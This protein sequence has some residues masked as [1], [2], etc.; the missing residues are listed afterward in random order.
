[1]KPLPLLLSLTTAAALGSAVAQTEVPASFALPSDAADPNAPGFQV[2]VVQADQ[3][4]VGFVALETTSARA[5]AQLAGLLTDPAT[6]QPYR[7][8]ADTTSFKP[9]GTYDEPFVIDYEQA[10]GATSGIPGIPGTTQSTD[11]IALEAVTYLDLAA[12]TYS[13]VVNSDDGFR[14]AVGS[15]ARDW[16]KR[17]T[18]G[19]FEG[20]R[21]AADTVFN[22]R[23]TQAGLYS[24][25]LLWYEGGGGANV[26]W[27]S[28]EPGNPANRVLINDSSNPAGIKAYR[29]ITAPRPAFVRYVAPAPNESGVSPT[30]LIQVLLGDGDAAQ[31][32]RNSIELYLN[33]AKVSATV[34]QDGRQTRVEFDPP[35]LLPANSNHKVRLVFKDT[36]ATPN[37]RSEE[38]TF[39]VR[40]YVSIT[41]P[42]PLYFENF[43]GTAEGSLPVGWT[44]QTFTDQSGSSSD[45]DLEN[46]DSA[47]YATW[48][49]VEAS[50]FR[51]PFVTYSNPDNPDAWENDYKRVLSFNPANVVNGEVVR[52]LAK[53]RFVFGNSGYR[54]G[55]SQVMYLFSPDFDLRGKTDVFVAFHSLWEQNQDSF[56][57]LEYSVDGGGSWLPILYMLDGPDVIRD[58][59]GQIDAV[60]TLTTE[61]GDVARYDDPVTGETKGGFY[62]AFIAAPITQDLAPFISARVNDNPIESK[63]VELFRLPRADNQ[64]QVRFRFA[65][66]GTD[67]WYWGI[68]NF[69][70]YSIPVVNPPEIVRQPQDVAAVEGNPATFTVTASGTPPLTYQWYRG[71]QSIAGAT[72]ASYTIDEVTLSDNGALFYARV[73]NA[74]GTRDSAKAR[75]T[76]TPRPPAVFG[77]WNFD[78]GDLSRAAGVG[79][80]DYAD[81]EATRSLT[82]FETTDGVTVPHIGGQPAKFMRVPVFEDR[83]NGY[84]LTMPMPP[85]G[86]G[87]YV[88]QYTIIWDVLLPTDINWMPFFNTDPGNG[89][90]A[91]FYVSNNGALGIGALGYSANGL[92]QPNTWY[93]VAFAANLAAGRVTYYLNGEPVRVR[94]GGSLRDGRFALY[95]ERDAGPDVR[96]FNEGDTSGNYTHEVLLNSFFFTD[97][98]MTADEI[99]ALGGPTATGIS[100]PTSP[101]IRLGVALQGS[102]LAIIWTGQPG[103]KLQRAT[104]LTNPDWRDVTGTLGASSAVEAITLP[105]AFYRL[106]SE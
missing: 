2:R 43:D 59:S 66:A 45:I 52:E 35:G 42:P 57:A 5:E 96:L 36:A 85:N 53:G 25:R 90:D 82:S 61:Y 87:D 98:T 15:D 6:G 38:W 100:A 105:A 10:G 58:G 72:T 91:D 26:A 71:D 73:S 37:T 51:G 30:A 54:N 28:A 63:R 20:G 78:G 106:A 3:A 12:G 70:L 60:A 8:V 65:H 88:N 67:S 93:R 83:G 19:Q 39:T 76:V 17:V 14:V 49:V 33:D 23:I 11:S 31:I 102:N 99:K 46:L 48:T 27:Y 81:G 9:D 56:A 95:S 62:G 21:A 22:F 103:V 50:R 69:G 94:T 55:R 1:M 86:G 80:L 47:A 4:Q 84:S 44:Q 68:D 92:I 97:R 79:T 24:F 75:L 101:R 29:A 104:S 34:Q 77:L 16:F 7:N 89:N 18:L 32:D 74:A 13:M 41:L 40:D 64:A